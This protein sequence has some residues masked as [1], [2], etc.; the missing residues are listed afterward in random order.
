MQIG[1]LNYHEP[2][3][4]RLLPKVSDTLV[5]HDGISYILDIVA[6]FGLIQIMKLAILILIHLDIINLQ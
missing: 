5:Y 2:R 3:Y 6:F 4:L 1:L